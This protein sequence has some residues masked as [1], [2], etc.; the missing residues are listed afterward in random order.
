MTAESLPFHMSKPT[1]RIYVA[2]LQPPTPF[3]HVLCDHFRAVAV[4]TNNESIAERRLAINPNVK[5]FVS[6]IDD[7]SG[8]SSNRSFSSF[9]ICF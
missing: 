6:E 3:G 5:R 4:A 2:V 7:A 1:E 9:A 8:H